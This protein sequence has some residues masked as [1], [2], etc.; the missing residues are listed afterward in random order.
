MNKILRLWIIVLIIIMLGILIIAIS[1]INLSSIESETTYYKNGISEQSYSER[2]ADYSSGNV[3]NSDLC[4]W[5]YFW[6]EC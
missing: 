5:G 6:A 1:I 2:Y 4:Y 3:S